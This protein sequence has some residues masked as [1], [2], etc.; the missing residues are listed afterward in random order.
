MDVL[1]VR[2]CWSVGRHIVEFEQGGEKRAGYGKRLLTELAEN[3]TAEF[4][5]GFDASSLRNMRFFYKAFPI[6]ATN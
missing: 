3:L 4:G 1:Q 6:C 5:K 2:T